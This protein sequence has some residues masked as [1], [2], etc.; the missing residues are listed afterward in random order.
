MSAASLPA[1]AILAAESS[2]SLPT[3]D[4]PT[5]VP[6][7]VV[8]LAVALVA[9]LLSRRLGHAL[10][11]LAT[12]G[13]A[14]WSLVVPTGV[15]LETSF[16]GFEAVLLNVDP[17]SRLMGVIFGLIG[18]A[19]VLYSYSSAA[20][21]R[22]TAFAL[23]YVG[24]SLG[25]VYAGDWLTMVFFWE[26]M[27]V[28]STLL[29]WDYG[30][31]AVRAGFRY[32]IYHGLGGSLLMAAVVWQYTQVGS[33]LFTAADG[34]VAGVPAVLAAIGIGVNVGFVGLHTWLPDTYPRPHVAASVFLSV[35]TTKTGVYGLARAFPDGNLAIAY[36]GAAMA[37][38]GVVY[39]LLQNDMRRLLSYHIQSQVGYMVAG[40]GVGTALAT[41]GAFAHV[42]NHILYKALL[43]MTAGVV[44]ARTGKQ[45]LKY[46]GGL[47]R[48]LPV[49]ALA[50]T[51]AALSISGFPGFNGFVSKGMITAAA[52][53]EHLDGI[54][55]IL[56][57]AGVGTFMSF[58]KFGYYAFLKGGTGTWTLQPS[59]TGQRVAMLGV[60][61]LCVVLG[62][63]PDALF[64]LLP[65]ST[66]D[67][68]PFTLSHL[69]EGFLL[70]ALGVVG[71]AALKKPLSKIGTGIDVDVVIE[72]AAFYGTRGL[73]RGV[74]ELF[75]AVD[76]LV[77]IGT[78][79]A[80]DVASD[81]YTVARGTVGRLFGITDEDVRDGSFRAGI[82]TSILLVLAVL[83]ATLVGLL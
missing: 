81:P 43:F 77:V 39:A 40:V 20:E 79:A 59:A 30:G 1:V 68:H 6:P 73:V 78:T 17:F 31:E 36:M 49:T 46:L 52:H 10:G 28:T 14:V 15:Y 65:G 3:A 57:A 70:A 35:Y 33:F 42:F 74:T 50:F 55:Y 19:A 80:V 7:A 53:K 63:Y 24:T 21:N 23:G 27:A 56:L 29:V 22:Q 62:L 2:V 83:A 76:R 25:A 45:S 9:P 51:A 34:I 47:G 72:P 13:V 44:I 26:L 60:A 58:I 64:A 61:A 4:V 12:G 16:L 37:L 8:V 54:F 66:A 18:A 41:A 32:A 5:V 75:A 69:G 48:V 38:V 11:V 82:A 71:F 67:A